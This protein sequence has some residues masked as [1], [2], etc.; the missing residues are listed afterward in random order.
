MTLSYTMCIIH[1]LKVPEHI[2]QLRVL[3]HMP[4]NVNQINLCF[5]DKNDDSSTTEL[6]HCNLSPFS[7]FYNL[8]S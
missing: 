4:E 2:R 6:I 7:N 3:L 1:Y 5:K 8:S